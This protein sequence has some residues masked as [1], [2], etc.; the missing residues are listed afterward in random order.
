MTKE[1]EIS[2]AL[3]SNYQTRTPPRLAYTYAGDPAKG[4]ETM[5]KG[6]FR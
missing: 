2:I 3:D 5:R 4:F 1:L 6:D